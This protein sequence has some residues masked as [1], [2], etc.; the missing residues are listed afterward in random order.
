VHHAKGASVDDLRLLSIERI[1]DL[2]PDIKAVAGILS[3]STGIIGSHT[4]MITMI[5]ELEALGGIVAYRSPALSGRAENGL[6]TMDT[7][8][9]GSLSVAAR[10]VINCGGLNARHIANSICGTPARSVPTPN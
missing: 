1:K 4:F 10:T 5:R 9:E 8:G 2:E 6:I 7:G 3:P